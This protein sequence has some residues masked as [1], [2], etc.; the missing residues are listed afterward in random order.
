MGEQLQDTKESSEL[1]E[2][3]FLWD[4]YRYR[5]EHCWN[6]V[7]KIT[8]A[9][10]AILIIPYIKPDITRSLGMLILALPSTAIGLV[11]FSY[12]RLDRELDVLAKVKKAHR[13]R[14]GRTHPGIGHEEHES[15]FK[16]H[17]QWYLRTLAG[18][19]VVEIIALLFSVKFPDLTAVPM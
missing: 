4:E 10:V 17:V 8:A 1:A 9:V 16:R 7:F 6:L 2:A 5:H 15:T 3:R 11:L 12:F 14:Q 13:S 18:L 19:A